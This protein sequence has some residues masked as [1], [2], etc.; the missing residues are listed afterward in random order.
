MPIIINTKLSDD[1]Q[2]I[3]P[4]TPIGNLIIIISEARNEQTKKQTKRSG[5]APN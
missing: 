1:S 3:P 2:R 4:S 5:V